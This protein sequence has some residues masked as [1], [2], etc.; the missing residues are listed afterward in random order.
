MTKTTYYYKRKRKPKKTKPLS[1]DTTAIRMVSAKARDW[2]YEYLSELFEIEF[3]ASQTKDCSKQI[4][5]RAK[6]IAAYLKRI[7]KT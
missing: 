5:K 2:D 6:G 7:S 1:I 4:Q 3:D